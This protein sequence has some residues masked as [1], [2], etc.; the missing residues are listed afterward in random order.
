MILMQPKQKSAEIV[1]VTVK[2]LF[3]VYYKWQMKKK[4]LAFQLECEE[5]PIR[6]WR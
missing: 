2:L 5:R 6:I 4:P 1:A 3:Y